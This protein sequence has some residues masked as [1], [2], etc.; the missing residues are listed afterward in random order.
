[1]K[2]LE[3]NKIEVNG[4]ENERRN[5][6]QNIQ[7]ENMESYA[8]ETNT[9]CNISKFRENE[10]V[11]VAGRVVFFRDLGKLVFGKLRDFNGTVQFSM[12]ESILNNF[13]K[14]KKLIDLGDIIGISGNLYKTQSGEITIQVDYFKIL[15]KAFLPLPD[16]YKGMENEEL[17]LRL[18][19]LDLVTDDK[20]KDLFKIRFKVINSIKNFLISRDFIEVETPILQPIASGAAANPFKTHHDAL[21]IELFLRIAPEL[22]LKRLLVGGFNKVFEIGKCFRNE[23]IDRTHLQEFTMLE[24]YQAYIS[25]EELMDLAIN[26]LQFAVRS[27]SENLKIND[28][29]FNNIPKI[30]YV[31]FLKNYGNIEFHRLEEKDYI[32]NYAKENDI[33]LKH[34]T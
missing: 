7:K 10:N 30:S 11:K 3:N 14:I 4:L 12:N 23:G 34:C 2:N 26:L 25:Y 13:Q 17:K 21:D 6:L 19:Y 22:Y 33:S 24:F 27:I 31:D 16:K 20:T 28:I 15:R 32:E 1:M 9:D 8:F 29:D 5:K 18:R